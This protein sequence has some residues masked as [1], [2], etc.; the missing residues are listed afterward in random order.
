M[1]NT[2]LPDNIEPMIR[3]AKTGKIGYITSICGNFARVEWL[4][5]HVTQTALFVLEPAVKEHA[6]D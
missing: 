5:G 2:W 3:H 1:T 6:H 4:T